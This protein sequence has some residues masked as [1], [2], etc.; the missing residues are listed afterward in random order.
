LKLLS[1]VFLGFYE[2]IQSWI[3]LSSSYFIPHYRHYCIQ[4]IPKAYGNFPNFFAAL[5]NPFVILPLTI[6]YI[7]KYRL[8]LIKFISTF[9]DISKPYLLFL[10]GIMMAFPPTGSIIWLLFNATLMINITFSFIRFLIP[11]SDW[12]ITNIFN[13]PFSEESLLFNSI[14]FGLSQIFNSWLPIYIM[15]GAT[16]TG[17]AAIQLQDTF[18]S[19]YHYFTKKKNQPAE[20]VQTPEFTRF[21]SNNRSFT[22]QSYEQIRSPFSELKKIQPLLPFL[23]GISDHGI[24]YYP[25]YGDTALNQLQDLK[26]ELLS[27][28]DNFFLTHAAEKN[29]WDIV[30]FLLKNPRVSLNAN[31]KD[32]F[33]LLKAIET[34]QWNIISKLLALPAFSIFPLT[35]GK[36]LCFSLLIEKAL[37]ARHKDTLKKIIK[38]E[39]YN[40][41]TIQTKINILII[42][43]KIRSRSILNFM[44]NDIPLM[45]QL[46]YKDFNMIFL[47]LPSGFIKQLSFHCSRFV[48]HIQSEYIE[49]QIMK[50]ISIQHLVSINQIKT[51]SSIARLYQDI[52][53]FIRSKNDNKLHIIS[54]MKL[55]QAK[56]EYLQLSAARNNYQESAQQPTEVILANQLFEHVRNHYRDNFEAKQTLENS[57][58]EVIEYEIKTYL[59]NQI[60]IE[61]QENIEKNYYPKASQKIINLIN[62][63]KIALLN[64]HFELNLYLIR[65]LEKF[66]PNDIS[67]IQTAWLSYNALHDIDNNNWKLLIRPDTEKIIHSTRE[68]ALEEDT[69][70][71]NSLASDVVRER[72]AY[73]WLAVN[74]PTYPDPDNFRLGNFVGII[75]SIYRTNGFGQSCCYPGHLTNIAKMGLHHPIAEPLTLDELIN[76]AVL[77]PV[78]HAF[79]QELHTHA[80]WTIEDKQNKLISLTYIN[81]Q[82]AEELFYDRITPTVDLEFEGFFLR[83]YNPDL[84]KKILTEILKNDRYANR[85]LSENERNEIQYGIEYK[86]RSIGSNPF[87]LTALN[88]LILD[89]HCIKED[90]NFD[91]MCPFVP[92]SHKH[93]LYLELAIMLSNRLDFLS[94]TELPKV[95]DFNQISTLSQQLINAV[96]DKS[97]A[98]EFVTA[99]RALGFIIKVDKIQDLHNKIAEPPVLMQFNSRIT[100]SRTRGD[101]TPA[102]S[103]QEMPG[104]GTAQETV[105]Y[106]KPP[107]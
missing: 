8:N 35:F 36:Q 67:A 59:L 23:S 43:A 74:D 88:E 66:V 32:C 100:R 96:V 49:N 34:K 18:K 55:L 44:L 22:Q 37:E 33:I 19:I 14:A 48:S 17:F 97:D 104:N 72:I 106:L 60:L 77:S 70:I 5:F 76:Q 107:L 92:G 61:A 45:K 57:S 95:K 28:N 80:N 12:E 63:S 89:S 26:E 6:L 98:T 9:F 47:N 91:E 65:Q 13:Y 85:L 56:N 68:S 7:L 62:D 99:F 83:K 1:T 64:G 50:G 41:Y 81:D 10:F 54:A 29:R 15:G 101:A 102:E 2:L 38:S 40:L 11:G 16:I 90:I 30:D 73:Y 82:N 78:L 79:K 94:G 27:E 53:K 39:I 105:P 84:S 75:S 71:T 86:L 31:C 46:K 51:F 87:I 4:L 3:I 93:K 52:Y 24:G 20:K 21:S 69:P 25:P 42:A 103:I 58:V